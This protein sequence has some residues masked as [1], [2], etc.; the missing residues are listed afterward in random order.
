MAELK[1]AEEQRAVGAVW[2]YMRLLRRAKERGCVY[3]SVVGIILRLPAQRL[4]LSPAS[5]SRN[6]VSEKP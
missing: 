6:P 3:S 2:W 5:S 1:S 4:S